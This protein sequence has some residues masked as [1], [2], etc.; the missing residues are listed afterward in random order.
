VSR[1]QPQTVEERFRVKVRP[2]ETGDCLLWIAAQDGHGYGQM[3]V[4]GRPVKA[5]RLAWT[6]A[7]GPIPPG[8]SIDHLCRVRLCVNP[9]HLEVVTLAENTRRQIE[10][11][12]HPRSNQTHCRNG[13]PFNEA[14]T[15]FVKGSRVCRTCRA[16]ANA[17]YRA[18]QKAA[19]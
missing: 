5:H 11:V 18:R 14:N 15:R 7:R 16:A 19:S 3:N 10:A 4:G 17:A 1:W 12:G 13:H 2:A 9:D 8:L 6:F